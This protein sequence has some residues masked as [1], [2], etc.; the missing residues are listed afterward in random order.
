MGDVDFGDNALID[1]DGLQLRW[2]DRWLKG[3]DNGIEREPHV[4]CS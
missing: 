1:L 2:F 3:I 4:S